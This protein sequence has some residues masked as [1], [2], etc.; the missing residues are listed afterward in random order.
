MILLVESSRRRVVLLHRLPVLTSSQ[1]LL[2]H[3][4]RLSPRPPSSPLLAPTVLLPAYRQTRSHH[5]TEALSPVL[6]LSCS[7]S[8]LLF[9][10]PALPLS[11]SSSLLLFLSPA[12]PLPPPACSTTFGPPAQAYV[13]PHPP[14]SRHSCSGTQVDKMTGRR[15]RSTLPCT[16]TH[17]A[18]TGEETQIPGKQCV[19]QWRTDV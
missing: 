9:L 5:R 13:S 15:K 7:S 6:P 8:L 2:T 3:L 19:R 1:S 17:L 16:L 11:C 4:L 18:D 10:S 12:F 14:T